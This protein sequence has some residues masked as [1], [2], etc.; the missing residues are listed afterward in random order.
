MVNQSA[1]CSPLNACA[2]VI[3]KSGGLPLRLPQDSSAGDSPKKYGADGLPSSIP[4][5]VVPL[6]QH[7]MLFWTKAHVFIF[8]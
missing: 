7:K 3:R 5:L 1:T 2:R 8:V 6:G 4:S